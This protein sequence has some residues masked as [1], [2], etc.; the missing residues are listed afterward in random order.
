MQ[1]KYPIMLGFD[2]QLFN[3]AAGGAA[4]GGAPA[5]DGAAAGV[6]GA[7]PKAGS[8]S[9]PGGSRRETSGANGAQKDASAAGNS[10]VAGSNG[11]GNAKT[12][13]E[14]RKAYRELMDSPEYKD[15]YTEDT[16]RIIN[17][18]FKET[19][20][21]QDSLEAQK[22]IMDMLMQKF[23][24]EDGDAG[25]LL[26]ALENDNA[27]WEEAAEAEGLT[28]EQYKAMK[29]LERENAE[30]KK[31]EQRKQSEE[32]YRNQMA[33]WMNEAEKVKEMYSSFD[34]EA[35]VK[36]PHFM[37]LLKARLP[38]KEAYEVVHMEEIK[39]AEAKRAAEI[40]SQQ[41][42]ANIRSKGSRPAENGMSSNS[43]VMTNT[44][45]HNLTPAQRADLARRAMR[46]EK[47]LK[48]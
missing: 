12:L 24:I 32:A 36:N 41:M 13:E 47:N 6:S 16:Q 25:K 34:L 27:M 19:K 17:K 8:M 20:G 10:S 26:K 37:S 4:A 18:R 2:L 39:A 14:R 35:E 7:L 11:E 31:I 21:L 28:V 46:G 44:D 22:P 23:K 42:Q 5:G 48:F 30:F 1:K 9:N 43:A 38:M 40:A 29:K 33:A 15:I 45:V 3:G